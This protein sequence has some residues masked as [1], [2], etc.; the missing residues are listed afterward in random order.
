MFSFLCKIK[1]KFFIFIKNFIDLNILN[2]LAISCY[3]IL[4]GRGQGAAKHLPMHKTAHNKE[5]FAQNVISTKKLCKPLFLKIYFIDYAITVVPFPPLYSPLPFKSPSTCITP[6]LSSC[7][8]VIH[9][10]FLTSTFPILF[11]TCPS[12]LCTYHLCYLFPVVYPPSPLPFPDD[13]PPSNH[14][15]CDS[16]FILIICCLFLFLFF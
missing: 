16:V 14:H 2:M 11:L 15:C 3:W 6:T 10:S 4:V 8:W 1:V 7:P 9:I 5:L 13:N 12:L